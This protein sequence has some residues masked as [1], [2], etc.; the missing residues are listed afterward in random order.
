MKL[1]AEV[2]TAEQLEDV[3]ENKHIDMVYAPYS[4]ISDEYCCYSD[5]I[6]LIPPVFLSDCENII[7]Q[8]F[9]KLK[10]IGFNKALVHT[11]GHVELFLAE[12]F[13]LY[14]G[15]RLNCLN[16]DGIDFFLKNNLTDIIISPEITA[17][18][19]SSFKNKKI[20][21][22]AYGFLPLMITRICPIS[23]DKPCNKYCCNQMII[24]RKGNKLSVICSENSV[25]I[26]NSDVLYL[27]D[28]LDSINNAE[29]ALL[30]FTTEKNVNE[31]ISAYV[32][33]KRSDIKNF[34]RGLYFRGIEVQNE[35][36]G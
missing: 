1:R 25:E 27:A 21:F 19:L 10:K 26:L 2:Y 9:K 13:E 29:F 14:G 33:R 31:I 34:T 20:G 3:L 6:I 4:I 11:I 16:S 8:E 23:N 15:Y 32:T 22:V 7:I 36:K 5:K 28:K 17:A 18:K 30:K 24:D 35:H 12:D